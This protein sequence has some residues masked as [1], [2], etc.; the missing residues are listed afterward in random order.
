MEIKPEKHVITNSRNAERC[1]GN[2]IEN[3]RDFI[4]WWIKPLK[5][6]ESRNIGEI[7]RGAETK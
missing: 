6:G 5:N 2:Q 4:G 7:Y 1:K 3:D